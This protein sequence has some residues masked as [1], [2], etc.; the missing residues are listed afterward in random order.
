ML[1]CICLTQGSSS[2]VNEN[3]NALVMSEHTLNAMKTP[4]IG[5]SDLPLSL[6]SFKSPNSAFTFE[7]PSN[8]RGRGHH[9]ISHPL[10]LIREMGLRQLREESSPCWRQTVLC[11]RTLDSLS[12]ASDPKAVP[13]SCSP[14]KSH[15]MVYKIEWFSLDVKC[16]PELW[17]YCAMIALKTPVYSLCQ[18]SSSLYKMSKLKLPLSLI[19]LEGRHFSPLEA[20]NSRSC[21]K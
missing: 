17:L 13:Q 15:T 9:T 2:S 20:L 12:V 3:Y 18:L 5:I 11:N 1:G 7:C 6:L 21:I 16:K 10:W 14:R 4:S 19:Y 8:L